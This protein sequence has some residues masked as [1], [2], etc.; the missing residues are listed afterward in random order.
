[1]VSCPAC[2]IRLFDGLS[3]INVKSLILVKI[4]L[5][6]MSQATLQYPRICHVSNP[7]IICGI[8]AGFPRSRQRISAE[9]S[10][11]ICRIVLRA[12]AQSESSKAS[13]ELRE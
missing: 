13:V 7:Q 3:L 4:D 9:S 11:S 10:K 12:S 1:M 2:P 8:A 6:Y 5:R